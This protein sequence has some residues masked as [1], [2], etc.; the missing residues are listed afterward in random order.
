MGSSYDGRNEGD[1]GSSK[2]SQSSVVDSVVADSADADKDSKDRTNIDDDEQSN[3]DDDNASGSGSGSGNDAV[4]EI[5]ASI[6]TSASDPVL[7]INSSSMLQAN[8]NQ[9]WTNSSDPSLG[10]AKTKSKD[11]KLIAK[12]TSTR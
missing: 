5:Q 6:A 10:A 8:R 7:E 3:K 4:S 11:R 12:R 1:E 9:V 2:Q